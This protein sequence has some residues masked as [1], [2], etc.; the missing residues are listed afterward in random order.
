MPVLKILPSL[1]VPY[2]EMCSRSIAA[3]IC[4]A[5]CMSTRI[6]LPPGRSAMDTPRIQASSSAIQHSTP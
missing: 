6:K 4:Y 2:V 5:G 1:A 3:R